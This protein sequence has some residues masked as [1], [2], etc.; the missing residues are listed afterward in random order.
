MKN[1]KMHL[2]MVAILSML[3]VGFS[4]LADNH[5]QPQTEPHSSK[6]SRIFASDTEFGFCSGFDYYF[7]S[8]E[9]TRRAERYALDDAE[10][11]CT[12]QKGKPAPV[13][14]CSSICFPMFME[15]TAPYQSVDC[16]AQCYLDCQ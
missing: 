10:R 12:A 9:I 2:A 5:L 14:D 13:G 11:Q 1:T 8:L 3:S 16:S 7:C 6:S 15:P 4:A